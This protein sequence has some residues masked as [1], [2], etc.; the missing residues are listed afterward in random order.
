MKLKAKISVWVGKDVFAPG[1]VFVIRDKKEAQSL[2]DRGFA[3]ATD[4]AVTS[5]PAAEQSELIPAE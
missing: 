5:K 1:E 2:I 4:G 3:E